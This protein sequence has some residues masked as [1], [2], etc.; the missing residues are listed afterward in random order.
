MKRAY[1]ETNVINK[2]LQ[3]G[4]TGLDLKNLLHDNDY[5]PCFGIH[6]IYELART[7]LDESGFERGKILFNILNELDPSYQPT[8]QNIIDQEV[9]KLR[10]GAAVLPFLDNINIAAT[11]QEVDKLSRGNFDAQA[12]Q[13]I[14]AREDSISKNFKFDYRKYIK[15]LEQNETVDNPRTFEQVLEKMQP[16]IPKLIFEMLRRRVSILEAKEMHIKLDYFPAIRTLALSNAYLTAICIMHMTAPSK[17][18]IDDYRHLVEAS[19]C[20]VF[21]TGDDQLYKTVPRINHVIENLKWDN[22]IKGK[23][24]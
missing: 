4:F 6:G 22:L 21:I 17:D 10:T 23:Q 20:D 13:F 11:K 1:L 3:E 15:M 5:T 8:I 14:I 9:I 16:H 2:A 24:G 7:F 19:Y 18:K 12:R